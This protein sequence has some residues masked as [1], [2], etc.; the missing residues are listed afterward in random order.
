MRRG[1]YDEE[2]LITCLSEGDEGAFEQL[3]NRYRQKTFSFAYRV[4]CSEEAALEIS[5]EVFLQVWLRREKLVGVRNFSAYLRGITRNVIFDEL[6]R[7]SR[8]NSR[9]EKLWNNRSATSQEA[10]SGMISREYLRVLEEAVDR[11]PPQQQLVFTLSRENGLSNEEIALQ[12]NLSKNTV[13][14]HLVQALKSVKAYVQVHSDI[15]FSVLLIIFSA[16]FPQ[17][18]SQSA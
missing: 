11:L 5:Q 14:N 1:L 15:C 9:R 8:D 13:K 18:V 4:L 7:I 10:D 3:F 17:A 2:K 16:S 6:K 12:L